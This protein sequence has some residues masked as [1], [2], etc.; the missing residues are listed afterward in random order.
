MTKFMPDEGIDPS[1]LNIR[2]IW[3][4]MLYASHLYRRSPN[5]FVNVEKTH[6][7]LPL[8]LV[9]LLV[10]QAQ[11]RFRLALSLTFER[12]IK[13]VH[14]LKGRLKV[15]ETQRRQSLRR[16]RV[17]CE[18]TTMTVNT[19][20]NRYVKAALATSVK[21]LSNLE[22]DGTL[23]QERLTLLKRARRFV[24]YLD[25]VGV[26]ERPTRSEVRALMRGHTQR[27]DRNVR[28]AAHLLLSMWLPTQTQGSVRAPRPLTTAR[29]LWTL[30]EKAVANFYRTHLDG[31]TWQVEAQRSLV[32]NP[33]GTLPTMYA[34]IV[35]TQRDTQDT[36]IIDTKCMPAS[37]SKTKGD[38]AVKLRS[39]HL[40]Q[41][42]SYMS[43]MSY[44]WSG[45]MEKKRKVEGILLYASTY[46]PKNGCDNQA[47]VDE[48]HWLQN[49][50][51][52]V[53]S[54]DLTGDFESFRRKLLQLVERI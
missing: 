13:E 35:L 32:W 36:I 29:E 21:L 31:K 39:A 46:S 17:V 49:A 40:Y 52:Q 41:M 18:Y 26:G 45:D 9:R 48:L 53:I 50:P 24:R 37:Y 3:M 15:L 42:F 16:G 6:E 2:N 47:T 11:K 19:P 12:E 27:E 25:E 54:L 10:E 5:A 22:V 1:T 51:L 44:A 33:S 28:D 34:D 14:A 23:N 8:L 30:F 7:V 43:A 20:T 38:E 4:L